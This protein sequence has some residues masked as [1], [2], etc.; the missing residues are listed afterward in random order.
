MGLLV[1][2]LVGLGFSYVGA[3]LLER[4]ISAYVNRQVLPERLL[5]GP[6]DRLE[7]REPQRV[8]SSQERSQR[9]PALSVESLSSEVLADVTSALTN[10]GYKKR[11]ASET[12]RR[13]VETLGTDKSLQELIVAA[14]Q[15]NRREAW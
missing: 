9:L 5:E 15:M 4:L 3:R 13:V 7:A 12:A 1:W 8:Q 2:L 6:R 14:L 10:L 11:E